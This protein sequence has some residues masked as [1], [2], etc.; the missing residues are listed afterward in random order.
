MSADE[1]KSFDDGIDGE[2]SSAKGRKRPASSDDAALNSDDIRKL[3]NRRAY[4]RQCAAKG[5]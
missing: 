4:N 5:K 1:A 2:D 3:E